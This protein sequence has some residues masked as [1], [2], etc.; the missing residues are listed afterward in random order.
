MQTILY[1]KKIHSYSVDTNTIVIS[2]KDVKFSSSYE[3]IG[4]KETK[5]FELSHSTGSEWDPS[6][7]WVYK[8]ECGMILHVTNDDVTEENAE[9]YLKSKTG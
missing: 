4:E 6:T 3:I 5:V 1:N 9:A 2:G 8:S 7:I